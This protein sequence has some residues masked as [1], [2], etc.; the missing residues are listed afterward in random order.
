MFHNFRLNILTVFFSVG[1][2]IWVN[3]ANFLHHLSKPL[4]HLK[5]TIVQTGTCVLALIDYRRC[6]FLTISH[7][8]GYVPG[9]NTYSHRATTKVAR[10]LYVF[11]PVNEFDA[12]VAIVFLILGWY[13]LLMVTQAAY[14]S[15]FVLIKNVPIPLNSVVHWNARPIAPPCHH[16]PPFDGRHQFRDKVT[17]IVI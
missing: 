4:C 12:F 10:W 7:L 17:F 11:C 5:W 15:R 2:R 16:P 14:F 13:T 3:Q 8:I 9:Q 6:V 1:S